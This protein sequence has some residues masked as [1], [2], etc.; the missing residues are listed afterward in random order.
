ML[1]KKSKNEVTP[2]TEESFFLEENTFG[3]EWM[4]N[5]SQ[6]LGQA[7]EGE[8]A[9]DVYETT[10]DVVVKA[11]IAGVHGEDDLDITLTDEMVMIKG[12]RKEEKEV[13]KDSYHLQE[14]YWGSFSRSIN[15][16]AKVVPE[17]GKAEFRKGILTIRIPKA[18]ANKIKK[19]KVNLG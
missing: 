10:N 3:P 12:E 14:C 5:V 6:E 9:V 16:P 13:Q 18:S 11:P 2:V 1:A 8:L 7:I 19:L 15:L 4:D 17:E